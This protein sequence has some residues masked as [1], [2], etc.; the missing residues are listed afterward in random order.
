MSW[1]LLFW[2]RRYQGVLATARQNLLHELIDGPR[3]AH[4]ATL[5]PGGPDVQVPVD[6]LRAWPLI[7]V[8][9]GEP[10]PA[11]GRVL[12]G[13]ALA[14]ERIVMGFEQAGPQTA[15]RLGLCG[16]HAP[17][18]RIA[19]C[20][21]ALGDATRRAQLARS[22]MAAIAPPGG[23]KAPTRHGQHLAEQTVG[24]TVALAGLGLLVGDVAM[25]GAILRPDYATGPG[26]AFP[27]E[28]LQAIALCMH[29]GVVIRSPQAIE[30][31]AT[32]DMVVFDHH[33]F[34]DRR[35][36]EV[37]AVEVFPG[38]AELQV[39]AHA[40]AAFHDLEDERTAALASALHAQGIEP[41]DLRRIEIAADITLQAGDDRIK[42]GDLGDRA[43]AAGVPLRSGSR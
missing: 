18:R 9:A 36:L 40:A 4:V 14:D 31:L 8:A 21:L 23:V 20:R 5:E 39:L 12:E 3:F 1:M 35:V 13:W 38:F 33:P 28:T 17:R 37:N 19:N 16:Q 7:V 24:P 32:A 43:E 25:A 6:D 11:D 15:G 2:R 30:R 10:V 41:P 26:L 42:V 29:H 22:M 34:L 27:L